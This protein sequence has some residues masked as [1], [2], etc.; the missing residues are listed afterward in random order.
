MKTVFKFGRKSPLASAAFPGLASV[1]LFA[2][3]AI[4]AP[5]RAHAQAV[6]WT[7]RDL[8][9]D[10]FPTSEKVTFQ[11][12]DL[13]ADPAARRAV[14]QRLGYPLARARY[15]VYVASTAGHVDGYAIFDEE[16]GQHLPISFAVKL[17]PSG[18]VERHELVAYRE[19]RGDEV[20]DNRFRAQF[21]G[22]SARDSVRAGD[23]IVAVSGATISS[24]AMAVGCKRAL[25]LLDA[26][27][28]RP[29]REASASAHR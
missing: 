14:E 7:P 9:A 10:F 21:I 1:A 28:L 19:A 17:S 8:L 16:L 12:F 13:A 25:V 3:L 26:L 29:Q 2:L 22:K 24:R 4:L 5:A 18:L 15:T 27:V 20:R 23:D 6:F 11:Q